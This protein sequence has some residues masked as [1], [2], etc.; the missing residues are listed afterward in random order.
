MA[1]WL[2]YSSSFPYLVK[3]G[4]YCI[5]SQPHAKWFDFAD[6]LA[7]QTGN[8]FLL[9]C[10]QKD[11]GAALF[12]L[13]QL[14]K[15]CIVP[16]WIMFSCCP[17]KPKQHKCLYLQ[18]AYHFHKWLLSWTARDTWWLSLWI[19]L[20]IEFRDF[21]CHKYETLQLELKTTV[22]RL[23]SFVRWLQKE[24]IPVWPVGYR[25]KIRSQF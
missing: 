7:L 20:K 12:V 8:C 16:S 15:Q 2:P 10:Y 19:L 9:L 24:G 4:A 6:L 18:T 25:C 21:G 22:I 17:K 13:D 11:R 1:L 23:V 14:T 3:R 5:A